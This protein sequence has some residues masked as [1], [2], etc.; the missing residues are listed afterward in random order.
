MS[1]KSFSHKTFACNNS[2]NQYLKYIR[3]FRKGEV[4]LNDKFIIK[5]TNDAIVIGKEAIYF[6]ENYN[7]ISSQFNN[8]SIVKA[9][10]DIHGVG[11]IML[12]D[13]DFH[14]MYG[15]CSLL[16]REEA[17]NKIIISL[18]WMAYDINKRNVSQEKAKAIARKISSLNRSE[19]EKCYSKVNV[20]SKDDICVFKSGN[21]LLSTISNDN[22]IVNIKK[23]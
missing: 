4:V 19:L 7:K 14:G 22:Y 1:S 17:L 2:K 23:F 5:I 15:K 18:D 20:S 16:F 8:I 10:P 9:Q 21:L 12:K 3:F 6:E 13:V 11:L